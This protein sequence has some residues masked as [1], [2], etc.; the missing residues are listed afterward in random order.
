MQVQLYDPANDGFEAIAVDDY[1]PCTKNTGKPAFSQPNGEELWVLILEKCFAKSKYFGTYHAT[2]GG[3]P[4][5]A[6]YL[7]TGGKCTHWSSSGGEGWGGNTVCHK[8]EEKDGAKKYSLTLKFDDLKKPDDDM[9]EFVKA[10]VPK[11]WVMA[12]GS[13]GKDNTIEEG[14]GADG[15]IV[16]GHAYSILDCVHVDDIRL[17]RLRNPWGTFE[18]D[19]AWSNNSPTWDEHPKVKKQVAADLK[20]RGR[21]VIEPGA[22]W[23]SWEDFLVHF[24][25]I[26]VCQREQTMDHIALDANEDMGWC[27]PCTGCC[28]GCLDFY[29]L[30][31]GPAMLYCNRLVEMDDREGSWQNTSFKSCCCC[32]GASRPE[33]A[34]AKKELGASSGGK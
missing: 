3:L 9:F 26:D 10:G 23:M 18:W 19:K 29:L 30:C 5:Y 1:I 6:L 7:L 31:N 25:I 11:G 15:G 20:D 28:V 8:D 21:S 12:A 22:F 13:Q 16:P 2:E 24:S 34:D 33:A 4:C 17:I 32:C 27:G 14:R